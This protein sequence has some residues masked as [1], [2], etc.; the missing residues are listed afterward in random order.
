MRN[1]LKNIMIDL[2][3]PYIVHLGVIYD[4]GI[5]LEKSPIFTIFMQ[6]SDFLGFCFIKQPYSK[7]L[8]GKQKCCHALGP[9]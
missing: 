1:M 7:G 5:A 2:Q 8:S 9:F 3:K 6:K 4:G